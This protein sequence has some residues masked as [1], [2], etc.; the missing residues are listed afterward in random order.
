VADG[1]GARSQLAITYVCGASWDVVAAAL[2]DSSTKTAPAAW[3]VSP[4]T[5][6]RWRFHAA[7]TNGEVAAAIRGFV[8][9]RIS[10]SDIRRPA[11]SSSAT[12]AD[13]P[14]ASKAPRGAAVLPS[15]SVTSAVLLLPGAF[16]A[17]CIV[18]HLALG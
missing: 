6:I 1:G 18:L 4:Q 14:S 7:M 11:T 17:A 10:A 9:V 13:E 15:V 5:P 3:V 12:T 8:K 16:I 2:R